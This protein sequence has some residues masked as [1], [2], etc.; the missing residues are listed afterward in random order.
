M[1]LSH[2]YLS[3]YDICFRSELISVWFAHTFKEDARNPQMYH[4]ALHYT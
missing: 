4:Y 1:D 3:L 2:S